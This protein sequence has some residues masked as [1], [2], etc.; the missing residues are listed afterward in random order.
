MLDEQ[1]VDRARGRHTGD[2]DDRETR[3]EEQGSEDGAAPGGVVGQPGDIAEEAGDQRK[4]ARRGER[5]EARG[6]RNKDCLLYTSR[7]V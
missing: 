7:C 1:L 3:D 6:E 5:D 2:E 4:H